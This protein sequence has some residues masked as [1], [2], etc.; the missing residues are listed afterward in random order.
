M[1]MVVQVVRQKNWSEVDV[2]PRGVD[3]SPRG[4]VEKIGCNCFNM[5]K[6]MPIIVLLSR[7]MLCLK[8]LSITEGIL[9]RYWEIFTFFQTQ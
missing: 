4:V 6:L 9:V 5:R 8:F 2:S 1:A 7:M 3:V